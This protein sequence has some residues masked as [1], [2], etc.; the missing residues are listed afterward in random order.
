MIISGKLRTSLDILENSCEIV[1]W[2]EQ[3]LEIE[4]VG[5]GLYVPTVNYH[6][7][8]C[9]LVGRLILGHALA[10]SHPAERVLLQVHEQ[11]QH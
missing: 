6:V 8:E 9:F 4:N 11:Q 2:F 5:E 1:L 3:R 7:F 10:A